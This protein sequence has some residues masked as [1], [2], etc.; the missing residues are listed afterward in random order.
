MSGRVSEGISLK[1][2]LEKIGILEQVQIV[3]VVIHYA[4]WL[5]VLFLMLI[6]SE[7]IIYPFLTLFISGALNYKIGSP[8]GF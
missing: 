6:S 5:V 7:L 3:V 1:R 4:S 2:Y 8:K